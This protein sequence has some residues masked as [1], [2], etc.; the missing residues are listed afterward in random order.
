MQKVQTKT[1]SYIKDGKTDKNYTKTNKNVDIG[2]IS[3]YYRRVK[4]LKT[5]DK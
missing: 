4:V 2:Y 5:Q 1:E 3:C